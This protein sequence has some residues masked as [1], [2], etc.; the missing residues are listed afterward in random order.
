[1]ASSALALWPIVDEAIKFGSHNR[2]HTYRFFRWK[3]RP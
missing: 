2:R 3:C 1:L